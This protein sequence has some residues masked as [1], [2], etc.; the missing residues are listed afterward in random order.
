MTLSKWNACPEKC[1]TPCESISGDTQWIGT[2]FVVPHTIHS[3]IAD[4]QNSVLIIGEAPGS[5]E[6]EKREGFVDTERSAG[7]NLRDLLRKSNLAELAIEQCSLA[8]IIRCIPTKAGKIRRPSKVEITRCTPYLVSTLKQVQ[9]RVILL[10]GL[11][12]AK[13]FLG[14]KTLTEHIRESQKVEFNFPTAAISDPILRAAIEGY[15]PKVGPVLL[16]PIP[17]TSGRAW[18]TMHKTGEDQISRLSLYLARQH[19]ATE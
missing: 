4:G 7:R 6:N 17:H 5:K 13:S 3:P 8:N 10:V 18:S 15:M 16:V 2:K 9:P 11:T 1:R 19:T 14:N 12:A